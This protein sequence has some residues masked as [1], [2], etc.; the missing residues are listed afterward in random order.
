M[1]MFS[2][3]AL[4]GTAISVIIHGYLT[5]HY[6]PL[7]FAAAASPSVCNIGGK[8][9]CDAV[10][11]SNY[12]ALFGI[13]VSIFG[14]VVNVILF[15]MILL[16]W[17][18]WSDNTP[19]LR[20]AALFLAGSSLAASF[21]MGGI[22]IFLLSNYCLFCIA[23]YFLSLIIFECI[24][25]TQTEPFFP[26]IK[27][28]LPVLWAQSQSLI[29]TFVAIPVLA[30][31]I[32]QGFLQNFGADQMDR[33]VGMVIQEWQA[34]PPKEI[35][36]KPM[37]VTGP[38]RSQA[39]MTISEFADFRCSHCAH[40]VSSLHAF[41]KSRPDVR[42]EFFSFP[43]DGECNGD[44]RNA[45]GLSCHL[46]YAVQCAETKGK[47]WAL[48]G[49]VFQNQD[50]L[51]QAQTVNE[52]KEKLLPIYADLQLPVGEMETCIADPAT[53]DSVSSQ[54]KQGELAGV[55]GT[56]TIFV[57]Q[58]LLSRGQALPVLEKAYSLSK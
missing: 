40:A 17:L 37:L 51:I 36:A 28:D 52:L 2:R 4:L 15:G 35:T 56:P 12:S 26:G 3:I 55:G 13:P 43:L 21:V 34:N 48:H 5:L 54:A 1:K 23:L 58:K 30:Y 33:I 38:E 49:Q 31:L 7:Q 45:N 22:S 47:G 27:S 11:A 6:Y 41:T 10:S 44:P 42:F 14:M 24:R 16:A 50:Q 25:R 18:E 53:K 46:A 8:F 20:R 19:R 32:H 57:N 39:K 9:N 29:W